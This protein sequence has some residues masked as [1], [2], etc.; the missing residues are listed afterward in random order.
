M[1][2]GC[3]SDGFNGRRGISRVRSGRKEKTGMMKRILASGLVLGLLIIATGADAARDIEVRVSVPTSGWSVQ[4]MEMREVD[5]EL[6]TVSRLISP[7]PGAFTLQV[8]SEVAQTISGSWPDL[9]VRH[10]VMGRTWK[11]ED[12]EQS[13]YTFIDAWEDLPEAYEGGRV[14]YRDDA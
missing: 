1:K 7:P 9:P 11:W 2:S 3:K 4:I 10:F 14:L 8:I 6:W 5:G 13:D 12:A